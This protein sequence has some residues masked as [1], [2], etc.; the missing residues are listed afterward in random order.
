MIRASGISCHACICLIFLWK[1]NLVSLS[2]AG[3]IW[4]SAVVGLLHD[5]FLPVVSNRYSIC[6]DQSIFKWICPPFSNSN[7][8]SLARIAPLATEQIT[9]DETRAPFK[10][11]AEKKSTTLCINSAGSYDGRTDFFFTIS[12]T[13]SSALSCFFFS[14]KYASLKSLTVC[15]F[16]PGSFPPNSLTVAAIPCWAAC[17]PVSA[18]YTYVHLQYFWRFLLLS[19]L[20]RNSS[21]TAF[22]S[23]LVKESS[24]FKTSDGFDL[25]K[26]L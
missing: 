15:L 7:D 20:F 11:K 24:F 8:L 1:S 18:L 16:K 6:R 23:L 25:L 2:N 14:S 13:S 5:I 21:A 3:A 9:D 10:H 26:Y 4:I 12:L 17:F 19:S 22:F